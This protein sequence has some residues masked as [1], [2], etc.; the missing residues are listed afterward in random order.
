MSFCGSLYYKQYNNVARSPR[1]VRF[2][3]LVSRDE[4]IGQLNTDDIKKKTE[5]R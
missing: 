5:N 1:R 4:S 2:C 3:S